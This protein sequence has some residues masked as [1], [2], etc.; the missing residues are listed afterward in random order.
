MG[1]YNFNKHENWGMEM[2]EL[3]IFFLKKQLFQL[4]YLLDFS[5]LFFFGW[6][7]LFMDS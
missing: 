7:V 1:I 5:F 6:E 4:L 3:L 2:N